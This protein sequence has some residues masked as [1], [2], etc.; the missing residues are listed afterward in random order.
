VDQRWSFKAR[1]LG[2]CLR[3]LL[4]LRGETRI[5]SFNRSSSAMRSSPQVGF[6]AA[7]RRVRHLS[8]ADTGGL[9]TSLDFQRQKVAKSGSGGQPI[10]VPDLR[11]S[12]PANQRSERAGEVQNGRQLSSVWP[13]SLVLEIVT[14]VFAGTGFRRRLRKKAVNRLTLSKP[15]LFTTQA[16]FENCRKR[17]C[18]SRSFHNHH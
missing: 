15:T 6:S 17:R 8:F 12:R 1:A 18:T 13:S 3:Y 5:P 11:S 7:I 14:A 4:T 2:L 9:P 16:S 10:R